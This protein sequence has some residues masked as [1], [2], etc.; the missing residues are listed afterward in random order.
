[1]LSL[2]F[3]NKEAKLYDKNFLGKSKS[4]KINA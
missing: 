4:Y 2:V 1:M 3:Y